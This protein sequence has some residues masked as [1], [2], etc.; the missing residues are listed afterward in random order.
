MALTY[1]NL[2]TESFNQIKNFINGSLTDPRNRF[3]K[4]WVHA[5]I[6]DLTAKGFDGYP[7]F[8]INVDLNEQSPSLDIKENERNF[9]I[10]IGV[11]SDEATQIDTLAD[12]FLAKFRTVLT[13]FK[14]KSIGSSSLSTQI[15]NGKKIYYRDIGL[16]TKKR[17]IT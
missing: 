10:T 6:P 17:L 12:E 11:F 3:K 9:R 2:Y 1:S 8:V 4:N 5:S 15:I 7:F 14:A 13:D 16:L